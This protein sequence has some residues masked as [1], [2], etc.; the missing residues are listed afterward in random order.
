MSINVSSGKINKSNTNSDIKLLI[1]GQASSNYK[2]REIISPADKEEALSLYGY[3][4]LYEAYCLLY[5][6]GIKNIYLSN[7]YSFSDYIRLTDKILHYDFDY[8]VPIGIYFSDK[9]YNSILDI[10]QYYVEYILKQLAAV[11]SL[12]TVL[13]TERH[14]SLYEDFDHYVL[15]MSN[16]ETEFMDMFNYESAS[17]LESYGNNINFVYNNLK[18]ISYSNLIL[19]ALY[20]GRDY[21]KYFNSLKGYTAV[22]DITNIDIKSLRAMYFKNNYY[23]DNVTLENPFNFKK[24]NDIYSNALIDDVIKRTIK[25]IDLDKYKGKL[26]NQYTALQIETEIVKCLKNLKGMLFKEYTINNVGFKKNEPTSGYVVIDYSIV[27]YGTL[28]SI[29]VIMGV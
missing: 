15:S 28:E 11:N 8:F 9:F 1:A 5:D 18:N 13:M 25:S 12:T 20:V 7:C 24:T 26:Y 3:S 16:I 19:A 6:M 2:A 4:E 29:N 21:S 23:L 22:Y 17:F 14:A 27:P 10:D